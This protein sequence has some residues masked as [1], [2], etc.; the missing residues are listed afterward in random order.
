MLDEPPPDRQRIRGPYDPEQTPRVTLPPARPSTHP[1]SRHEANAARLIGLAIAS[2]N[3][4]SSLRGA[5]AAFA[6]RGSSSRRRALRLVLAQNCRARG[7]RPR[8]HLSPAR[9]RVAPRR[10]HVTDP[11]RRQAAA[12][13]I[14]SA[15]FAWPAFRS[16]SRMTLR[17]RELRGAPD[18]VRRRCRLTHV[19]SPYQTRART[20]SRSVVVAAPA[21]AATKSQ[22]SVATRHRRGSTLEPLLRVVLPW[23]TRGSG[24]PP[25]G[26][27]RRIQLEQIEAWPA[28][29][30]SRHPYEPCVSP[31]YD[32]CSARSELLL[33]L[34]EVQRPLLRRDRRLDEQDAVRRFIGL[35]EVLELACERFDAVQMAVGLGASLRF[36]SAEARAQRAAES[37]RENQRAQLRTTSS[38]RLIGASQPKSSDTRDAV[39]SLGAGAN[40]LT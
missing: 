12:A 26:S 32:G 17:V 15:C 11:E 23:P 18:G 22:T 13:A 7:R 9:W 38:H 24:T 4:G 1:P 2:A 39:N 31:R 30:P 8:R 19:A 14:S 28:A 21:S 20:R 3:E 37:C 40:R 34:L 27:G 6:W 25:R 29:N 16:R 35:L 10:R 5:S 36:I 33:E